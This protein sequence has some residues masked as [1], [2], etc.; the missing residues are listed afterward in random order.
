MKKLTLLVVLVMAVGLLA[1]CPAPTPQIIEVEKPVIVEK[2]VVQTV[3]VTPAPSPLSGKVVMWTSPMTGSDE[4]PL[5]G[6]LIRRFNGEYPNVEVEVEFVPWGDRDTK[7]ASALA[8]G[9]APDVAYVFVEAYLGWVQDGVVEPLDAYISADNW[10]D[11]LP[12]WQRAVTDDI[13]KGAGAESKIWMAPYLAAGANYAYN[14]DLFEAA[15]LDPEQPPT[16]WDELLAACE[17]LTQ[18]TDGDGEI[19]QFCVEL[20]GKAGYN[21]WMAFWWQAGGNMLADDFGSVTISEAPGLEAM[22]FMKALADNQY[23][24]ADLISG[25]GNANTL[26]E[27]GKLAI[28]FFWTTMAPQYRSSLAD[29]FAY[30]YMPVLKKVDQYAFAAYGGWGMF[31]SSKNK[32]AAGAW[33]DFLMRPESMTF[34]LQWV[35]AHG[36]QFTGVSQ[37]TVA[38]V[39]SD[40]PVY[41][42]AMADLSDHG[43]THQLTPSYM[44]YTDLLGDQIEQVLL[45]GKDPQQ[46]LDD[47]A[48]SINEAF[49][50]SK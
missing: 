12:L 28:K 43:Y 10:A 8:A 29:K 13:G 27:D 6:E 5:Y 50:A 15:G 20:Q 1:S 36:T 22:N 31:S 11:V 25:A 18:D 44:E 4:E 26:W 16:T 34:W 3:E 2:E 49:E 41:N 48:A 39:T 19:D 17:K 21:Q 47:A 24:P 45:K 14:K 23:A 40:D 42:A 9:T 30:G 7:F 46:A 32:D 35:Q 38:T 37:T 33:I